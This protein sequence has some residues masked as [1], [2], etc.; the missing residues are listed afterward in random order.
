MT[1]VAV[2]FAYMGHGVRRLEG[3]VVILLYVAFAVVVASR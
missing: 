1:A 3:G 2:V